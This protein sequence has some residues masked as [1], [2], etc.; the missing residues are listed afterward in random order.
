MLLAEPRAQI[1]Q[2]A[3]LAAEGS[4]RII[5]RPRDAAL[6]GRTVHANGHRLGAADQRKR[7]VRFVLSGALFDAAP[8]EKAIANRGKRAHGKPMHNHGVGAELFAKGISA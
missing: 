2:P 8:L 1:N 6:A 3:A 4:K 7:Y 5:I